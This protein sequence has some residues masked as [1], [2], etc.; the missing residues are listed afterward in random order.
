M[1]SPIVKLPKSKGVLTKL[2]L[3]SR[4]ASCLEVCRLLHENNELHEIFAP[5]ARA[6]TFVGER[7]DTD[8]IVT[9][10]AVYRRKVSS[11]LNSM[12]NVFR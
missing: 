9:R 10:N 8:Q 7:I 2:Q 5:Q 3:L 11:V 4:M 6:E 1:K 12:R